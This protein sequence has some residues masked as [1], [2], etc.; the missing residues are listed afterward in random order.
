MK[1]HSWLLTILFLGLCVYPICSYAYNPFDRAAE[2]RRLEKE[3]KQEEMVAL[4]NE[5]LIIIEDTPRIVTK[6]VLQER[7]MDNAIYRVKVTKRCNARFV[8]IWEPEDVL[9]LNLN[10]TSVHRYNVWF[11]QID[12]DSKLSRSLAR[13]RMFSQRKK[14]GRNALVFPKHV[15]KR[16]IYIMNKPQSYDA[17][18]LYEE[19]KEAEDYGNV[20]SPEAAVFKVTDKDAEIDD[21][22]YT[23][24]KHNLYYVVFD[25]KVKLK[26]DI[27]DDT[28]KIVDGK[29]EKSKISNSKTKRRR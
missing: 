29:I 23:C 9:N 10:A 22:E 28:L 27:V 21:T 12:K 26:K 2:K 20:I 18:E 24:D 19:I 14:T 15:M 7:L 13:T 25:K 8:V 3:K 17:E 6:D 16:V 4:V 11:I 1:R 5:R